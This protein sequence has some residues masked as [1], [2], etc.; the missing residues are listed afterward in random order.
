MDTHFLKYPSPSVALCLFPCCHVGDRFVAG[1]PRDDRWRL[2][3]LRAKR[4]NP[5]V[6]IPRSGRGVCG[7]S[8]SLRP[9]VSLSP[10]DDTWSLMSLQ[11][12]ALAPKRGN[13]QLCI[14]CLSIR[15]YSTVTLLAKFLGWSTSAPRWTAM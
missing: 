2:M 9:F 6:H 1:A 4:S 12:Q 14:P 7:P 13:P 8:V 3:S 10:R 15:A 11:A 5:Q